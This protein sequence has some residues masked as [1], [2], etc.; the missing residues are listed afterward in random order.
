MIS[1]EIGSGSG[2]V[3]SSLALLLERKGYK[4]CMYFATDINEEACKATMKTFM[5]NG[6]DE[7]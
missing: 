1:L 2:V 7:S 6:I 5:D 3:I 4:D